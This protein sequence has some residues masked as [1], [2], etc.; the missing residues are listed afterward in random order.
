MIAVARCA[1]RQPTSPT[2]IVIL[3]PALM[4]V[5]VFIEISFRVGL[6]G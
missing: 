6:Y 1:V 2:P 5:R 3:R 4:L